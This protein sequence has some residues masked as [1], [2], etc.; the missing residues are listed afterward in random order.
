M[1]RNLGAAYYLAVNRDCTH[2]Q[3]SATSLN[4]DKLELRQ[5]M[6]DYHLYALSLLAI[7]NL[8]AM[9]FLL[10]LLVRIEQRR[11]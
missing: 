3:V 4:L 2:R 11:A 5:K 1:E 6:A 7:G 10:F 8:L 9:S